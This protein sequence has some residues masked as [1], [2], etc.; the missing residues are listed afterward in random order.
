[1]FCLSESSSS[2][3]LN[4]RDLKWDKIAFVVGLFLSLQE[5]WGLCSWAE[6]Y[7]WC[8]LSQGMIWC[9]GP[10]PWPEQAAL[11]T[12]EETWGSLPRLWILQAAEMRAE[13]DISETVMCFL[14]ASKVA[15]RKLSQRQGKAK[16]LRAPVWAGFCHL[17]VTAVLICLQSSVLNF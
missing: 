8:S 6:C 17:T 15:V 11:L 13:I 16:S 10:Q 4:S 2:A 5:Q 7:S 12:E 3:R 9:P 14:S 1:M